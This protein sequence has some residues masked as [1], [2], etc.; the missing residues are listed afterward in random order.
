MSK[1]K[2]TVF[3]IQ[4]SLDGT[5]ML[6]YNKKRTKCGEM[7]YDHSLDEMFGEKDKIYVLGHMDSDGRI[8]IQQRVNDRGW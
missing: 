5:S 3:K 4:R 1:N 2:L 7:P 6:I 8:G